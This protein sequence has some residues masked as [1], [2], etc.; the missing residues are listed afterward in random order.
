MLQSKDVK[1]QMGIEG[2]NIIE[3]IYNKLTANMILNGKKHKA[4]PAKFRKTRITTLII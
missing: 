2:H 4:F 3:A 1:W